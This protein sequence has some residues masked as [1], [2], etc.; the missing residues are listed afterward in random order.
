LRVRHKSQGESFIELAAIELT[1][2]REA[3]DAAA[4]LAHA[5]EL[6]CALW[7]AVKETPG[8]CLPRKRKRVAA[9]FIADP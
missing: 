5:W 2:A 4:H 3:G 1:A 6:A 7:A 9:R 8:T